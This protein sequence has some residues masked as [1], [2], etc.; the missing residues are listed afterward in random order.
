MQTKLSSLH[1]AIRE[2]FPTSP[3]Y[4]FENLKTYR[5]TKPKV[6]EIFEAEFDIILASKKL[7]A[8]IQ[9]VGLNHNFFTFIAPIYGELFRVIKGFEKTLRGSLPEIR[10]YYEGLELP[11]SEDVYSL[12]REEFDLMI[13]EVQKEF[14]ATKLRNPDW[15]EW[16]GQE[17]R[18]DKVNE[19]FKEASKAKEKK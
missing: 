19:L 3:H 5:T 14:E 6:D 13:P 7:E 17:I 18:W 9:S 2:K 11:L 1:L 15:T 10:K 4:A 8:A 12:M 16:E